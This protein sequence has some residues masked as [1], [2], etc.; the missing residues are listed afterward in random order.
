AAGTTIEMSREE[1]AVA[2]S[3]VKTWELIAAGEH[4]YCLVLEDD[5]YFRAGFARSFDK[6]WSAIGSIDGS[7]ALDMLYVS[8]EE[9]R[10]GAE[11]AIAPAPLRHPIRGVWQLSGY[12]LSRQGALKLLDALPVRGPVDLWINFT[13]ADLNVFA[14]R[15]P[16]IRQRLDLPSSNFYSALPV[17]AQVGL[18]NREQAP[19]IGRPNMDGPIFGLGRPG[20]AVSALATALSM[21]GFR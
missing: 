9:S 20:T 1:I 4:E 2:S 21:L 16:T 8:F 13:F 18:I 11:W 6:A 5:V 7:T 15:R 10:G 3:H 12:V 19:T 14:V 17:L